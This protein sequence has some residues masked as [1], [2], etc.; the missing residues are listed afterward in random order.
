MK[1]LSLSRVVTLFIG[2]FVLIT[3]QSCTS[4]TTYF[5]WADT[6]I[7][8]ELDSYFDLT[9]EQN[10]HVDQ[11]LDV[12]LDQ[13]RLQEVPKYIAF[14]EEV[15]RRTQGNLSAGDVDWFWDRLTQFNVNIAH[16]LKEDTVFFILSL[17][18]GQIPHLE[19]QLAEANE[20]WLEEREEA[21]KRTNEERL[22]KIYQNIEKWLGSVTDQ[23]KEQI[24]AMGPPENVGFKYWQ[25]SRFRSQQKFLRIVKSV[26][27][28]PELESS[29]LDWYLNAK[30]DYS[31]EHKAYLQK[32]DQR[33]I[34]LVLILSQTATEDQKKFFHNKVKDYINQLNEIYSG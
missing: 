23:Q 11:R 20:E 14:L 18:P 6:Y 9:S 33:T 27:S 32:R 1:K 8:W 31:E 10:D 29:L 24:V 17:N 3:T 4:L 25:E 34:Q 28:K 15:E 16:L 2:T 19:E 12:L 7:S 21:L 26:S 5:N 13:Y 22:D 30:R